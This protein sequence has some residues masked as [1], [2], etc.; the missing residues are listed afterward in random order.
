MISEIELRAE[1]E[2]AKLTQGVARPNSATQ[3]N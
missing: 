3:E 2:L 1:V